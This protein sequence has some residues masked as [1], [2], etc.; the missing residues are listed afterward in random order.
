MG[1]VVLRAEDLSFAYPGVPLFSGVDLQLYAGETKVLLGPS[2]SG[3]TTLIHLLAGIER[4]KKGRIFWGDV[5]I[6][7]LPEEKLA[8]LRRGFL[9]LVF[10]RHHLLPELTV[11]QNV[12]LPGL[13][14]GRVD[15]ERVRTLLFRVG[16]SGAADRRPPQLSGGERQRVAVARALYSRPSLILADEPTGALDADNS[17]KVLALLLE[18]AEAEGAALF[19][20]THDAHLVRGLPAFALQSGR[21]VPVGW[22]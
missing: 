20:A 10:Q 15:W 21:L 2:G 19:V 18:L 22:A 6:T 4:P 9:G 7:A 11:A 13:I 14:A 5:E 3:K 12:A 16:L 8:R 1:G 17:R